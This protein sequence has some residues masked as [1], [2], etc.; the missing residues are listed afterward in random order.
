MAERK[1]RY[2][3]SSNIVTR[4]SS[5]GQVSVSTYIAEEFVTT[6][7]TSARVNGKLA[8]KPQVMSREFWSTSPNVSPGSSIYAA[9]AVDA[10]LTVQRPAMRDHSRT[11]LER[12]YNTAY[13]R[14]TSMM[15]QG[16]R[17][18]L[19]VTFAQLSMT[20]QMLTNY[21]NRGSRN[22]RDWYYQLLVLLEE[23]R[24]TP[25]RKRHFL[26]K[27]WISQL[28]D[29][30]LEYK[31]GLK[32]LLSDIY[33][34]MEVA[35]SNRAYKD[36]WITARGTSQVTGVTKFTSN[37]TA[38]IS[39]RVRTTLAARVSVTN[40]NAAL[41]NKLGLINPA[42]VAWD[43]IPWSWVAGMFVNATA[44]T[45]SLTDF[46]GYSVND[47]SRTTSRDLTAVILAPGVGTKSST[48]SAKQVWK[49][50]NRV[51]VSSFA[52][53]YVDFRVPK[54]N[55]ELMF[56]AAALAAQRIRKLSSLITRAYDFVRR[57]L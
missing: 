40:H 54:L 7:N 38:Q 16:A 26:A 55:F 11:P 42:S 17:A 14:F 53:P 27:R 28:G 4:V 36:R 50:K 29:L 46:V 52:R 24:R 43:L 12:S 37:Q 31:F 32:P 48:G 10:C 5:T 49:T 33:S 45:R 34:A 22:L 21:Y 15:G 19:G 30:V 41:A 6:W 2:S 8:L 25:V 57:Y 35:V 44:L 9:S 3:K 23:W 18:S 1:R 56:T 20:R 47:G 39:G 51:L 13:N